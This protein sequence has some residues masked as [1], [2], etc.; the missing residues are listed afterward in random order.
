MIKAV[1]FDFGNV[2]AVQDTSCYKKMSALAGIPVEK[3]QSFFWKRRVEYD[4]GDI[5]GVRMY[6]EGF[7][8]AGYPEKADDERLCRELALLDT[9][10]WLD[11]DKAV[12]E[13][14]RQLKREGYL[15][16]VLS[17]MPWDFLDLHEKEIPLF[18]EA[19]TAVFSCREKL[20]K[21]QPEIYRVLLYRLGTIPE[22]TVFFDDI[23]VNVVAACDLG[24]KGILWNGLEQAREDFN[25]IKIG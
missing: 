15:I 12:I 22:E 18:V 6:V 11:Y 10:S 21:P 8:E 5:L 1:V 20:I 9:G 7:L 24:I 2:I 4:R 16:G 13:W 17:N 14:T 19:D 23:E 25:R 3:I